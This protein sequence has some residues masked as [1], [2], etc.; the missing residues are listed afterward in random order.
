MAEV[1]KGSLSTVL[2]QWSVGPK[3]PPKGLRS[4][5]WRGFRGA[6]GPLPRRKCF[7]TAKGNQVNIPELPEELFMAATQ[8]KVET[9]AE[10]P[11]RV[12]FSD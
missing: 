7:Q 10:V 2:G 4:G 6:F 9:L 12:I 11:V 3:R 1:E 5:A 8:R